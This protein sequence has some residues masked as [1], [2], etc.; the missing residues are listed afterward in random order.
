MGVCKSAYMYMYH[1]N[2]MHHHC[3]I[4]AH[5]EWVYGGKLLPA[6][7]PAVGVV[8]GG[9]E[10]PIRLRCAVQGLILDM[11]GTLV[12]SEPLSLEACME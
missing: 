3:T 2:P 12:D 1:D 11:D 7:P 5:E 9:P 10:P 4:T 6:S 8:W